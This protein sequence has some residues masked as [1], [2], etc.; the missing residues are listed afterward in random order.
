MDSFLSH[1]YIVKISPLSVLRCSHMTITKDLHKPT[2]EFL[3]PFLEQC[4]DVD[5][6]ASVLAP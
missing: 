1:G 5:P 6:A 2:L 3:Q 4:P